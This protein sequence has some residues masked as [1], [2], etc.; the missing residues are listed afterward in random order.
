MLAPLHARIARR[1]PLRYAVPT[2]L[3]LRSADAV[4]HATANADLR[5]ADISDTADT[6]DTADTV[7]TADTADTAPR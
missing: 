1:T 7:D 5:A 6:A 4:P 3:L 2:P